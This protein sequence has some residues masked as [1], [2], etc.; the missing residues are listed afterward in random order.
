MKSSPPALRF[1]G[2]PAFADPASL[3]LSAPAT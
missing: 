1:A 3:S 2:I